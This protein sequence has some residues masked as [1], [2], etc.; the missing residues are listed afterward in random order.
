MDEGLVTFLV[1]C[2]LASDVAGVSRVVLF[3]KGGPVSELL[4]LF[5]NKASDD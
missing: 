4:R 5:L 3:A 1:K 2:T